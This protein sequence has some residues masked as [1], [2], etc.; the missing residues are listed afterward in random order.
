MANAK[1]FGRRTFRFVAL[2]SLI[3][4][5]PG[6]ATTERFSTP[7]R[8][9]LGEDSSREIVQAQHTEAIAPK[10]NSSGGPQSEQARRYPIDL[11]TA[12][13]LANA[14]NTQ[15]AHAQERI[16]EAEAQLDQA[17]V[18]LLPS[19]N[20]GASYNHHDGRIQETSGTV[21]EA[22]RSDGYAGL[23]AG[24]IGAGT[25]I[26]PGV[27]VRSDLADAIFLPLAARQG[28][29]AREA[30]SRAVLNN[31][32]L[33]VVVAY[34]ELLRAKAAVAIAQESYE[35]AAE[36]A[37]VTENYAK[38]GEGL[39]SDAERA[40]VERSLR[41]RELEAARETLQVRSAQLAELLRLDPQV[42]LD[43]I[44]A[45]VVP[46]SLV[47]EDRPLADLISTA[48]QNRP[49]LEQSR[50]LVQLACERLCQ[51]KY[52]P[53]LPSVVLGYSVGGF[54]GGP[55]SSLVNT[56]DR[57]D[58]DAMLYWQLRNLGAGDRARTDERRSQYR[59]AQTV[60]VAVMDRVSSEVS[61]AYAQ[62]K[63]RRKQIAIA[64]GAVGRALKSFQLNRSRIFEKQGLPI[65]VLQA[66]QSLAAT[67]REYLAAVIDYNEAQF[68][69]YTTLGQPASQATP[70]PHAAPAKTPVI[71]PIPELP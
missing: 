11:P 52:G 54:G 4:V 58:F 34:Q 35:N 9:A 53:L 28:V 29:R 18:L 47:G 37:R 46:V 49:E 61:Q 40:A 22:S 57:S 65:E 44:D 24:A 41:E 67:R 43:P 27:S 51:A 10:L 23:G 25:V 2:A 12:L 50:A 13:R 63:S 1:H 31:V 69:L 38:A 3:A 70:E 20:A 33:D 71:L 64:E 66:I 32:L 39:Q 36:L 45:S 14:Q 7:P 59:Q 62:V 21:V 42:E 55:G 60:E 15:I 19:L 48:L 17:R 68:R 26:V 16:A 8:P 56:S 5:T 30:E 6:C